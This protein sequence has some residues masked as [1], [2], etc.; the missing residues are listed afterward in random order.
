MDN[1]G[2]GQDS[3]TGSATFERSLVLVLMVLAVSAVVA[4]S[5]NGLGLL[6]PAAD[7]DEGWVWGVRMAGGAAAVAGLAGLFVQRQRLRADRI[8]R[9]DPAVAALSTAATI[10]ILLTLTARLNPPATSQDDAGARATFSLTGWNPTGGDGSGE[11]LPARTMGG[12][13][14]IKGD[15]RPVDPPTEPIAA[16]DDEQ[17]L[18]QQVARIVSLVFT[19][20]LLSVVVVI[21]LLALARRLRHQPEKL[22]ADVTL[23]PADAEAGLEAS[24]VEVGGDS[25]DPRRQITNAYHRLLAALAVAGA[26]REP[27]EA[28]H[29]HLH[30]TLAPLGVH[31]ESLHRL[32]ELYVVA[33]FSA[34]PVTEQHRATAA[35]ALM[36]SLANLRAKHISPAA[37][38]NHPVP[39]EARA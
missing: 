28:P 38:G 15:P 30:R 1:G 18:L 9:P 27:Q 13:P 37:D 25:R 14:I 24:L 26:P 22:P 33:Q 3:F 35:D 17:G 32:A 2:Q 6:L 20:I 36:A 31:P 12:E 39:E 23:A 4:I 16:R 5:T 7:L 34:R 10:M 8:S 19:L 11:V 29:E 21:S